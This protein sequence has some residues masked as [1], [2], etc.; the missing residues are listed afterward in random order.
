MTWNFGVRTIAEFLSL[1]H[2]SDPISKEWAPY[3]LTRVVAVTSPIRQK[4]LCVCLSTQS[5]S[6]SRAQTNNTCV[7]VCPHSLHQVHVRRQKQPCVCLSTQ[8]TSGSRAQTKTSAC[9]FVNTVH[10]R[11]TCADNKVF[12]EEG[13][14][15]FF[16]SLPPAHLC[17][18]QHFRICL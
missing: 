9:L 17:G 1:I 13:R 2:T 10:I 6:G 11:F 7:F 16:P 18:D 15:S 12:F 8:S 3:Q 5:T 4:H 14:V